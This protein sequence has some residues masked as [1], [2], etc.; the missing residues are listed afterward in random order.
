M[1]NC[2]VAFIV[3][4]VCNSKLGQT[5]ICKISMETFYQDL[6]KPIHRHFTIIVCNVLLERQFSIYNLI[7]VYVHQSSCLGGCDLS[8]HAAVTDVTPN[9]RK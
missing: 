1:L 4:Y 7:E 8:E 9:V 2:P 6:L 5:Q 3:R